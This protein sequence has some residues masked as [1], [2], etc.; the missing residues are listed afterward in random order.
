MTLTARVFAWRKYHSYSGGNINR[1]ASRKKGQD[2]ATT[3]TAF[4]VKYVP[5]LLISG[6]SFPGVNWLH[7][8]RQPVMAVSSTGVFLQNKALVC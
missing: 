3:I 8:S 1:R 5:C 2:R 6:G 7:A 4:F